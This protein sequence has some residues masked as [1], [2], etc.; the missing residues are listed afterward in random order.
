MNKTIHEL[1]SL[2]QAQADDELIIYDVSEGESK[3]IQV[4]NLTNPNYS[5]EE[6]KTGGNWIDGKPIYRK[7]FAISGTVYSGSY[8]NIGITKPSG[9]DS[10]VSIK[11][12]SPND[13]LLYF[14]DNLYCASLGGTMSVSGYATVEYTKSTD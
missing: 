12:N 4:Q 5:T 6:Q 9:F 2:A 7:C 3:K 13:N 14:N 11:T 8:Q 10:L 1:N